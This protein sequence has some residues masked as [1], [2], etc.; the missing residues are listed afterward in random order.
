MPFIFRRLQRQSR[1][2]SRRCLV[3]IAILAFRRR[4][5]HIR[6]RRRLYRQRPP[7]RR[8][9][10]VRL[11]TMRINVPQNHRQNI[12]IWLRRRLLLIRLDELAIRRTFANQRH[13][14][15]KR[16]RF[17]GRLLSNL[18]ISLDFSRFYV[19]IARLPIALRTRLAHW[20]KFAYHAK[21]QNRRQ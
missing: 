14:L 18:L 19:A 12:R 20:N 15:R 2:I 11:P 8:Q 1:L 7:I 16:I 17:L 4:N 21:T 6:Q 9:R 5:R 10:L 3:V 13:Q